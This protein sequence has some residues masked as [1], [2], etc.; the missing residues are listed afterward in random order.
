[1]RLDRL[2]VEP[3]AR[4]RQDFLRGALD[5]H[6]PLDRALLLNGRHPVV[7][8]AARTKLL[9]RVL[10]AQGSTIDTEVERGGEERGFRRAAADVVGILGELGLVA[11]D[12]DRE[13]P[14]RELVRLRARA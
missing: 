14:S 1:E 13:R 6:E 4:E 12:A 9:Q 11:E 5:H 3:R 8:I 10:P 2:A 7:A